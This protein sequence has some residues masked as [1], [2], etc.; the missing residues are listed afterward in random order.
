MAGITRPYVAGFKRPMTA[1]KRIT[2]PILSNWVPSEGIQRHLGG[3]RAKPRRGASANGLHLRIRAACCRVSSRS[4]DL[5]KRKN[6]TRNR[7]RRAWRC[8]GGG[9]RE[10]SCD[11]RSHPAR[12]P[13]DGR[14][15]EGGSFVANPC[16]SET[17]ARCACGPCPSP[18]V[19]P[20]FFVRPSVHR[21]C[22]T[23]P[24]AACLPAT[25]PPSR[26]SA[27]RPWR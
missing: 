21:P 1:G 7:R 12:Q 14:C 23:G 25:R 20:D 4:E 19:R 11:R 5:D 10:R 2:D 16:S 27:A 17:A 13:A 3:V 8:L 18:A 26:R 9:F 6:T 15:N 24:L 22:G